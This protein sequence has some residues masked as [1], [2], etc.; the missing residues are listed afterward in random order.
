MNSIFENV[1]GPSPSLGSS[2]KK[3]PSRSPSLDSCQ[4]DSD[5]TRLGLETPTVV[6]NHATSYMTLLTQAQTFLPPT[7][8]FKNYF[9]VRFFLIIYAMKFRTDNSSNRIIAP[10]PKNRPLLYLKRKLFTYLQLPG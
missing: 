10:F 2:S 1:A 3:D 4:K 6:T 7:S 8:L 9:Q 5:S